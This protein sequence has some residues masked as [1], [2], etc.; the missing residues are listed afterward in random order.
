M[1]ARIVGIVLVHNEDVFVGQAVRNV[2]GFCDR[3]HV[4]DHLSTDHT[5]EI[6]QALAREYDHVDARRVRHARVS[7]QVIEP[8]V[9]T[10]TWVFRVDGDELY[11]PAGLARLRPTLVDGG[12]RH[13]FRLAG[14]AL[15]CVQLDIG[16]GLARGW[17]SPPSRPGVSLY[18]FAAL[19]RWSGCGERLHGGTIVFRPPYGMDCSDNIGER[20]AWEESPLRCLHACFLRRSSLDADPPKPRLNL[21]ELGTH[22]RGLVGAAM[23]ALRRRRPVPG[24]ELGSTWKDE[25]Y[26]RGEL[27]TKDVKPFFEAAKNLAPRSSSHRG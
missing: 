22:R 9:G 6:V 2:V 25:K 3:I 23:R 8:Y 19:E 13:I 26:R 27:V 5:W 1:A 12:F 14:H 15:N 7:H 24:G 11:D 16:R 21:S 4:V 10:D 20:M 18:N 17:L